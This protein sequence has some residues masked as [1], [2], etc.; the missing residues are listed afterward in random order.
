[1]DVSGTL[2]EARNKPFWVGFF[3]CFDF[4]VHTV[5]Q[6]LCLQEIIF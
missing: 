1:M 6:V 3:G 4:L 5:K 2:Y